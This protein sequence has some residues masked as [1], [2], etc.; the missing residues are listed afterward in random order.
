MVVLAETTLLMVV[1][2]GLVPTAP[3]MLVSAVP[4]TPLL[5]FQL[6]GAFQ[7]LRPGVATFQT[8]AAACDG[9]VLPSTSA[10]AAIVKRRREDNFF[11]SGGVDLVFMKGVGL[12]FTQNTAGPVQA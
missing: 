9:K 3:K 8:K 4:A 5:R 2:F 1:T 12:S 6:A 7:L 11:I 10:R